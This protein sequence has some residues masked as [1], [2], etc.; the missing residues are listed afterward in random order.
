MLLMP[1]PP[2]PL[3][4][5]EKEEPAAQKVVVFG[6]SR[7]AAKL[8][9]LLSAKG[10]P[11]KKVTATSPPVPILE[12][13]HRIFFF[14]GDEDLPAELLSQWK[15]AVALAHT[16]HCPTTLVLTNLSSFLQDDLLNHSKVSRL[17]P[18]IVEINGI[19][20]DLRAIAAADK[21]FSASLTGGEKTFLFAQGVPTTAKDYKPGPQEIIR[22]LEWQLQNLRR[23]KTPFPPLSFP[24]F[25]GRPL[26]SLLAV[27]FLFLSPLLFLTASTLLG[28][29]FLLDSR[30][31]LKNAKYDE[32][33]VESQKAQEFFSLAASVNGLLSPF[34]PARL[35][36]KSS[37]LLL[38]GKSLS[39]V[40][41][42]TAQ[43]LPQVQNLSDFILGKNDSLNL[44]ATT[45]EVRL[46]F[47][48]IARQL[49][50]IETQIAVVPSFLQPLLPSFTT[51]S[52]TRQTASQL[53]RVLTVLPLIVGQRD[54]SSEV[55]PRRRYLVV[56][57]NSTELRP[58]GGFVGSYAL[59]TFDSGRLLSY[60][61]N[62]IY[63]ADGQLKGRVPPPDEILHYLGQP[64][65]YMRDANFSPDWPLSASRLAWFLEKSTGETVDGVIAVNLPLVQKILAATGPLTIPD[66]N[67]TVSAEAFYHKAQFAAEINFFPGSTQKKDYLGAVAAALLQHLLEGQNANRL[68][69]AK[70]ILEG[71]QQKDLLFSFNNDQIQ[72]AVSLNNWGG[73]IAGTNCAHPQNNC[74]LIVEANFGANKANYFLKR[75][76]SI[77]H[78]I[79]KAGDVE[80]N[81]TI[82]FHNN[83]P[84][85]TWP[86]GHYRNYL[87]FLVPSSSQ[88]ITLSQSDDKTP[89][90]SSTLTADILSQ[91]PKNQFLVFK[92]PELTRQYPYAATTPVSSYGVFVT[93]PPRGNLSVNFAYR[94][95][96]KIDFLKKQVTYDFFLRKQPGLASDPV[97]I[98]LDFP[99]FLSPKITDSTTPVPPLAT[100]QALVYN[101]NLAQ[102]RQ[103]TVKFQIN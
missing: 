13:P 45:K 103:F 19:F 87:R 26:H 5:V 82:N 73:E 22:H 56:F 40:S 68:L 60:K 78:A 89:Q 9:T 76:L 14:A 3:I 96:V 31:L 101:T 29:K 42:T 16:H 25:L 70:A 55:L 23:Q 24:K 64:S 12:K 97:A 90:L 10:F 48:V 6:Q 99:S 38:L 39:E 71:L 77:K 85:D 83:S 27:T 28:A 37:H 84:T 59:V 88:F 66:F 51:L 61:V 15:E 43:T 4:R 52:Q 58:T 47:S 86:G 8:A 1:N 92:T 7:L 53:E 67:D 54:S 46:N 18:H 95:P 94:P 30:D 41:Q 98:T 35:G 81:V 80:V 63:A 33:L 75:S 62:D 34:V 74:L 36:E 69:L 72:N 102:D 11:V 49:G 2:R 17:T 93:I 57:Q 21:I 44:P 50:L 20:N 79:G 91:V 100:P 65:W 32:A